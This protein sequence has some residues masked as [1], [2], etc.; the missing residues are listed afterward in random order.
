MD[1]DVQLEKGELVPDG[2][3]RHDLLEEANLRAF[4]AG[5]SITRHGRPLPRR[6]CGRVNFG[7]QKLNIWPRD[8]EGRLI[9]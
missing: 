6:I 9:E 3:S 8:E 5:Y 7:V 4:R 2:V 1:S